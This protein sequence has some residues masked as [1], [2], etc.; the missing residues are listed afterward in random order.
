MSP[1]DQHDADCRCEWG[2]PGLDSLAPAAVVI[3]VDV[4]SFSTCVDVAV[5]R[6]AAIL[7]YPWNDAS[8]ADFAAAHR[9]V[10]AGPRR[11]ARYSLSPGSFVDVSAGLRCVLP[12]PNGAT[13]AVRAAA[14]GATVLAGCLR[15]AAAVAT[16]AR[17]LGATFSVC[18]AGERWPDGSLRVAIEDWL[19]A[20][21]ILRAL[22]GRRSAEATLAIAAFESGQHSVQAL[23]AASSSGRELIGRGFG[24]DVELAA[25]VDVSNHAARLEEGAFIKLWK[26]AVQ[27]R[28]MTSR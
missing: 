28:A 10:L 27:P 3:V 20:G 4:L 15:N 22:P 2:V 12:S 1:F 6:G 25:Q 16:A 26:P 24:A 7:P 8:A 19:A 9:A 5:G 13:L 23:L 14:T 11:T 21:A 17:G 18:P